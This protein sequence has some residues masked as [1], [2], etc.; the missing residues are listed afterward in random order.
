MAIKIIASLSLVALAGCAALTDRQAGT[1]SEAAMR[2][3]P[4]EGQFI[5]V[6]GR[7]VHAVVRGKGPDV[8][9]LHGAGGSTR[10]WTFSF[11]DK[12]SDRYRVIAFDRPGLGYTDRTS[13]SY[14]RAFTTQAE[15]PAEQAMMLRSAAAALGADAPII[16]GHS[17]G[18]TVALAWALEYPQ[19]VGGVVN[20]AG[21]S[22]PWPGNLGAYY[23][24][25][26]SSLGGVLVPPIISAFATNQRIEDTVAAIFEPQLVPD[27]YIEH[28][29]ATLSIRPN[30]LRANTRQVNNLRPFVVEMAPR[31]RNELTMP[32]E[33]V[34]GD[35]D[36]IVPLDIHSIPLSNAIPHATLTVL[37][38]VGHMPHH[39]APDVVED[40]IDRISAQ[41]RTQ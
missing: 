27:G 37:E 15:T 35:L 14:E 28:I 18:A 5:D 29:G 38:G 19:D 23:T 17:F 8:I 7:M 33:I 20:L 24:V 41:I 25:N 16:V 30:S 12:L 21:P 4:P 26:G 3:F 13:D 36:E 2:D 9:L 34:H 6:D 1:R 32:I 11:M 22:H 39:A 10:E 31:Y 40:A